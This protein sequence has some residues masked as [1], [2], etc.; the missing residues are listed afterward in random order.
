MNDIGS[1]LGALITWIMSIVAL[2]VTP[3]W[4]ALIGLLPLFLLPLIALWFFATGGAWTFAALTKRGPRI[5]I[6]S[7][8]PAP[9]PRDTN[10]LPIYSPGRPFSPRRAEVYPAGSVRDTDGAPLS[11]VCP[12]CAAVRLAELEGCAGCGMQIRQR[13]VPRFERPAGPPPGGSS[14]A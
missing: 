3:N 4:A 11:I 6:S 10:G 2:I 1:H 14:N 7:P 12:G 8:Q 13:V 9:A 5:T